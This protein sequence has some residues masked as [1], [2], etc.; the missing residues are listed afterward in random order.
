MKNTRKK[1]HPRNKMRRANIGF[2][3]REAEYARRR[4]LNPLPVPKI[5]KDRNGVMKITILLFHL[6]LL[7]LMI[8]SFQL[9]FW[10]LMEVLMGADGVI[11]LHGILLCGVKGVL[12]VACGIGV[13]GLCPVSWAIIVDSFQNWFRKKR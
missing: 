10:G 12:G 7:I 5:K 4:E 3:H 8:R 2:N 9:C 6:L 13:V 11:L 1:T